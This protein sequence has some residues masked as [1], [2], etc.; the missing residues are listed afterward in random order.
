LLFC[1]TTHIIHR[2]CQWSVP[3]FSILLLRLTCSCRHMQTH[4]SIHRQ[5]FSWWFFFVKTQTKQ[6][7]SKCKVP[8]R[9]EPLKHTQVQFLGFY[10]NSNNPRCS[11]C[12]G[13]FHNLS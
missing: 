10:V 5:A 8:M 13:T 3:T 7:T 4:V 6:D 1:C 2:S 9:R 11:C 12:L